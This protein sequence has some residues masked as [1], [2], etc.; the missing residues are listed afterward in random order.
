MDHHIKYDE[1]AWEKHVPIGILKNNYDD[2]GWSGVGGRWRQRNLDVIVKYINLLHDILKRP[3]M[4]L[5]VACFIGE[6]CGKLIEMKDIQHK[7]HYTGCDVTHK[8]IEFAANKYTNFEHV[9]FLVG[10]A[11]NLPFDNN[12]FDI[13]FNSGMLIH[14]DD[15]DLCIKEFSRVSKNVILIETTID[16]AQC[17]E[18]VHKFTDNMFLSYTYTSQYI[19]NIIKKYMVLVD[20]NVA[21]YVE[22]LQSHL[23]INRKLTQHNS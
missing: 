5:D 14:V 1:Q 23:F 21:P 11:K 12:T 20:I 4:I 10:N 2:L 16:K 7:F 3:V 8:Y 6:Y 15:V 13:V 18:R 22:G 19:E 9:N 17:T